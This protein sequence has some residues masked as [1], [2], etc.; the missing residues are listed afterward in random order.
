MHNM[1]IVDIVSWKQMPTHAADIA[2]RFVCNLY[3]QVS[4]LLP[5]MPGTILSQSFIEHLFSSQESSYQ[6]WPT[7]V[8][9]LSE[10]G[11]YTVDL[12]SEEALEGFTIRTLSVLHKKV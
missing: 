3:T 12:I 4:I 1:H 9:Q 8:G 6:Y 5:T 7:A 11:E 2:A 10:F